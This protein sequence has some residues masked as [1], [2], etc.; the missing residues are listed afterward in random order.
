[1]TPPPLAL[2]TDSPVSLGWRGHPSQ[3]ASQSVCSQAQ[4]PTLL[5]SE[6]LL[7]TGNVNNSLIT[8][9]F[10]DVSLSLYLSLSL[11]ARCYHQSSEETINEIPVM[12][13]N[14]PTSPLYPSAPQV[15]FTQS[16]TTEGRERGSRL[17]IFIYKLASGPT[18]STVSQLDSTRFV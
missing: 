10:C 3:P 18:A 8:S 4:H 7:I 5:S 9:P 14:G 16:F 1:M 6:I 11:P 17:G 12:A 2:N 15:L 13:H